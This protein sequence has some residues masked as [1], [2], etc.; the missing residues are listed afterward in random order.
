MRETRIENIKVTEISSSE[1][2]IRTE[3][4]HGNIIICAMGRV[5]L[6]LPGTISSYMD[7]IKTDS[8]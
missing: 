2:N 5:F 6:Q 1:Q 8:W 3:L 7:M 4:D